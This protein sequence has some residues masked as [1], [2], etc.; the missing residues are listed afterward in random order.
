MAGQRQSA[1]ELL[2]SG[3]KPAGTPKAIYKTKPPPDEHS[4]RTRP[5]NQISHATLPTHCDAR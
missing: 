2:V 5:Q 1:F 4:D 3:R